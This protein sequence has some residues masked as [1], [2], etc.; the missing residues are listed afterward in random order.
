[1][2][3]LDATT[4]EQTLNN[5]RP[6]SN[7]VPVDRPLNPASQLGPNVKRRDEQREWGAESGPNAAKQA[8]GFHPCL[9]P[10][11]PRS[12]RK[13]PLLLLNVPRRHVV[14]E[15][16]FSTRCQ[17]PALNGASRV[18]TAHLFVI[19]ALSVGSAHPTVL[20]FYS[21][22]SSYSWFRKNR[23]TIHQNIAGWLRLPAELNRSC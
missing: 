11:V 17:A 2:R 21:C 13:Q 8:T 22:H 10:T 6:H 19:A 18:G 9:V 20:R 3:Q 16:S 14:N 23:A 12:N 15:K 4:I 1:M 7:S 5:K